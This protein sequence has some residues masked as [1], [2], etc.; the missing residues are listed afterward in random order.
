[1]FFFT[2]SAYGKTASQTGPPAPKIQIPAWATTAEKPE[3]LKKPSNWSFFWS[4]WYKQKHKTPKITFETGMAAYYGSMEQWTFSR[5]EPFVKLRWAILDKYLQLYTIFALDYST[6]SYRNKNLKT[7][8]YSVSVDAK[9]QSAGAHSFGGGLQALLFG[10][11]DFNV[12]GYVQT[13][14][15]SLNNI[16]LNKAGLTLE[17]I[18]VDAAE[19]LKNY[20]DVTYNFSRFDCG[21]IISLRKSWFTVT[22]TVGYVQIKAEAS[23]ILKNGIED[24]LRKATKINDIYGSAL[25]PSR[26]DIDISSPFGMLGYKFKLYKRLYLN[27]EGTVAPTSDPDYYGSVSLIFET[28]N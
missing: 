18:S 3:K 5:L 9:L 10:W 13:Q 21:A 25:L 24:A 22:A 23:I 26:L 17:T 8:K 12:F 7:D 16:S 1:M 15:N 11:K 20:V 2:G 19:Q 14:S 28:K 4:Y 27:L 6:I